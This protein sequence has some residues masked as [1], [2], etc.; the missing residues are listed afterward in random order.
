[1][2]GATDE[3]ALTR[4]KE[5]SVAGRRHVA[6]R[7]IGLAALGLAGVV[8]FVWYRGNI[9]DYP[10]QAA[11]AVDALARGDFWDAVEQQ[12]NMG[13]FSVVLRAPFVAVAHAFGAGDLV[14]YRVG[15]VPCVAAAALLGAA[16]V[17]YFPSSARPR[18]L[19]LLVVLLAVA[20]PQAADAIELGHPEEL[21]GAAMCVG[22][23]VA[24]MRGRLVW[25]ALL[26][27]LA[28]A[29][30][31]WALLAV[32]PTILAVG[33]P[34]WWR[35]TV[36]AGGIVAVLM[37]PA[38]LANH[39]RLEAATREAAS[40]PAKVNYQSWWYLLDRDLPAWLPQ[41]TKPAI[42]LSAI[43]LTL[44]AYRRGNGAR[45][46]LP[47][48]ALLF[49]LRCVLDTQTNAYYH[50]PLLLA[51]LAWDM[52]MRRLL[53]YATLAVVG[54]LVL[55]NSYLASPTELYA[56]SVF[57]FAWTAGLAAYLVM[58]LRRRYVDDGRLVSAS[59][60][61]Q[62]DVTSAPE[63][64]RER[65]GSRALVTPFWGNFPPAWGVPLPEGIL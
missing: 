14:S 30:K 48:L 3:E 18:A 46:A 62:P 9:G 44:L 29:T 47:L 17:K 25:A 59:C 35:V 40:A 51:L 65:L 11:P 6:L 5:R 43:P 52:Q 53:P 63:A 61:A 55:T 42:V 4:N 8:A 26:L 33:R 19:G 38:L 45:R 20:T 16:L 50:V 12:P 60:V 32:G 28:I 54:L 1:M 56:A 21:L 10:E 34:H 37:L 49:L 31:Q 41:L 27:G 7:Q 15:A 24:G 13:P 36:A 64:R 58:A 2:E 22:A 23:V 57:Y 39:E